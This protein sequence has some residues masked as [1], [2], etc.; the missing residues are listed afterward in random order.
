[1]RPHDA[2]GPEIAHAVDDVILV[3]AHHSLIGQIPKETAGAARVG[4]HH[5]PVVLQ[6]GP[7]AAVVKT[8]QKLGGQE[9]FLLPHVFLRLAP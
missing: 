6:P 2:V 5:V 8:V 9:D 3:R 4:H 1:M 7:V